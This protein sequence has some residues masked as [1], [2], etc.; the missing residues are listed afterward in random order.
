VSQ[1]QLPLLLSLLC[2]AALA[3]AG[4]RPYVTECR[5]RL[6]Q[7]LAVFLLIGILAVAVFYP[8]TLFGEAEEFDPA[9]IWFPSLLAGHFLIATFLFLWWRLSRQSSLATFLHLSSKH[10]G[11][12]LRRG[13]LAG[14][15]G[16]VLTVVVT[17]AA[18]SLSAATGC[19]A[20]PTE[21]PPLMVWLAALPLAYKLAIVATAMTVEEAFYRGFLQPRVG[22]VV[23]S[24]FFALS[25]FSYGLPFMIVGVFAISLVIGLTLARTGNLL[26]CIIAH[27]VFD[28][29]QLFIVLPWAV[30]QWGTAGG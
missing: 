4:H 30:R 8:V 6:R 13:L 20:E 26:P 5:G 3:L 28:A 23:S 15:V 14:G 24:V 7:T 12:N 9:T 1:L 19:I 27:G 10:L 22:L 17:G 11:D 21:V 2:V 25:H 18:A 16:W 29:V